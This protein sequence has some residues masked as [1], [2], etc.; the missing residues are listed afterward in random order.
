[1]KRLRVEEIVVQSSDSEDGCDLAHSHRLLAPR[2]SHI[3]ATRMGVSSR[4]YRRMR[5]WRMP[6]I[7]YQILMCIHLL[8]GWVDMTYHGAEWFC[9]I[10]MVEAGLEEM[11]L[12]AF[13][14][15]S[16]KGPHM[17]F[18]SAAGFTTAASLSRR[19]AMYPAVKITCFTDISTCVRHKNYCGL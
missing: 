14:F 13:G 17:D 6:D 7:W 4:E 3:A 11:A 19:L 12:N 9:G 5:R 18:T 2:H 10:G 15:D 8:E 16:E 1:M